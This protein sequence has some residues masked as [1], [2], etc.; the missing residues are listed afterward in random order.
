[1][2]KKHTSGP[3]IY[4]IHDG[5]FYIFCSDDGMVADGHSDDIGIARM[6]GVG[7][8]AS[9][10]EQEANAQLIAAAPAQDLILRM[11]SLGIARIERSSTTPLV[12]FCFGGL[13]YAVTGGDWN[14][15]VGVVGWNRCLL[16]I[17]KAEK[18]S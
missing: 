6:R 3:W 14:A 2:S 17:E 5:S 1:V 9:P 7:R 12:E 16:A 10:A 4:G 11:L 8:G 15:V 18:Q 13:R